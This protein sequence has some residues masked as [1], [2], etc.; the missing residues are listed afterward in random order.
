M[1]HTEQQQQ[2]IQ[3]QSIDKRKV[4]R[5][6]SKHGSETNQILVRETRPALF[7]V[8]TECVCDGGAGAMSVCLSV[9]KTVRLKKLTA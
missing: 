6:Q 7:I 9:R 1:W 5:N 2:T 4:K 8:W 3:K